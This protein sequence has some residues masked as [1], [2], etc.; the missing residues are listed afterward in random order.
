[1]NKRKLKGHINRLGYFVN[2]GLRLEVMGQNTLT[3]DVCVSC[4][5]EPTVSWARNQPHRRSVHIQEN[6]YSICVSTLI[7][8]VPIP[9][10]DPHV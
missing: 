6:G 3:K 4:V 10:E 9:P 2:L 1:M 7:G 8:R 5:V